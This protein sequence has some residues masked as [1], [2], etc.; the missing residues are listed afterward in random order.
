MRPRYNKMEKIQSNEIS[1]VVKVNETW[2]Q[3]NKTRVAHVDGAFFFIDT[4]NLPF[5]T[6]GKP[7][8]K[9]KQSCKH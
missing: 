1:Y 2:E 3:S 6:I 4:K 7:N 5:G 9:T 8:R